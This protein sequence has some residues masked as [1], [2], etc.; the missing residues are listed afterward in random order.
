VQLHFLV[1]S[2]DEVVDDMRGGRI[3]TGA[4]EPLLA[5]EAL[6]YAGGIVDA[7]VSVVS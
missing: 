7:A 6:D 4:A 3:A 5:D 2:A 1:A